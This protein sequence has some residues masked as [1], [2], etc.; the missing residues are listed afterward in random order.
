[1]IAYHHNAVT[2]IFCRSKKSIRSKPS[3]LGLLEMSFDR[4]DTCPFV[5][6]GALTNGLN[7]CSQV[8]DFASELMPAIA[9]TTLYHWHRLLIDMANWSRTVVY[10]DD[11]FNSNGDVLVRLKPL[12]LHQLLLG[13]RTYLTKDAKKAIKYP[14]WRT[15]L[16]RANLLSHIVTHILKDDLSRDN[17]KSF[18]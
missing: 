14:S 12:L 8:Y 18:R 5:N 11:E 7:I 17:N 9:P 15:L 16:G 13:A 1:M 6:R 2:F 4:L 3:E 10:S